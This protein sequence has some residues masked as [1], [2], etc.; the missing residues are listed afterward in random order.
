MRDGF[1]DAFLTK[2]EQSKSDPHPRMRDKVVLI[3]SE[4]NSVEEIIL[5]LGKW[6]PTVIL[7]PL[8]KPK[9]EQIAQTHWVNSVPTVLLNQ[10]NKFGFA[11]EGRRLLNRCFNCSLRLRMKQ[12]HW[13]R[14]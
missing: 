7:G 4:K 9:A 8:L 10:I 5:K 14:T 6:K 13:P 12:L 2:S 1:F 3:D 11:E